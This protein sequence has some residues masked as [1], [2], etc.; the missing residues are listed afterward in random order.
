MPERFYEP[1]CLICGLVTGAGGKTNGAGL[2]INLLTAAPLDRSLLTFLS[3][4]AFR[5]IGDSLKMQLTDQV[6]ENAVREWPE[7]IYKISGAEME[8]NLKK[9]RDQLP[10]VAEKY[11][12]ILAK[13]IDLQGS[14]KKEKFKEI[15]EENYENNN[16]NNNQ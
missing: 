13:N 3:K 14:D 15:M 12:L 8:K 1:G 4:E 7:N 6:I 9:R 2:L 10:S 5:Q 16:Q 11:Y